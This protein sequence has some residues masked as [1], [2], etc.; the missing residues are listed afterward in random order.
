MHWPRPTPL[1]WWRGDYSDIRERIR[2]TG[3]LDVDEL[4]EAESGDSW[5]AFRREHGGEPTIDADWQELAQR[6]RSAQA[7]YRQRQADLALKLQ[8]EWEAKKR[9]HQLAKQATADQ[10]WNEVDEARAFWSAKDPTYL[11]QQYC[12]ITV[13]RRVKLYDTTFDAGRTYL[14]PIAVFYGIKGHG[15]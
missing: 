8:Q 1:L 12:R 9:A 7:R 5:N 14:V 11:M 6:E 10:E 3:R 2:R 4:W 15:G 13:Q